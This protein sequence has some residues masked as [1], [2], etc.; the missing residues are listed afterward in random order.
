[1]KSATRIMIS[2]FGILVGLA[3]I[4][5]GTGEVLQGS[6]APVGIMFP[7]WPDSAFFRS[8]NGEPAISLVPNLLVT[9]ILAIGFSL[10]FAV[11][12]IGFAERKHRGW[13][14]ALLSVVLLL[15]G[16]GVFPPVFGMLIAAAASRIHSAS[17][18]RLTHAPGGI[19]PILGKLW[20]WFFGASLIS[21]LSM[22]PGIPALNYFFGVHEPALILILLVCMF[23]FL[24]PAWISAIERDC[25][26]FPISAV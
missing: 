21:W 20:P 17:R 3:G 9:G 18:E 14:L 26:E 12:S 2:T 25:G 23:G 8:L 16:G 6:V 19:R 10:I 5:H 4:E 13:I 1:M 11:W 22:V 7:S 24:C 15:T